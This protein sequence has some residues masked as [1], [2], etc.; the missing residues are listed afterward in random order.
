MIDQAT[1]SVPGA[2][3]IPGLAF[4][5][6]RGEVDY[7][8]MVRILD[9]CNDADRLDYVNTVE[10]IAWVFAH[11]K[12]CDPERDMLFAE[13][14]GE[15]I[16]FSRVWWLEESAGEPENCRVER[17]YVSLGFVHPAWRRRGLGAAM[18]RYDEARLRDTARAHPAGIH[19]LFRAWAEGTQD[20]AHALFASA[21][22]APVRHLIMM[23]RPIGLPL[24][25]APLPPGLEVRP[26]DPNQI[27]AIWDAMWEARRDH[28]GYV[29]P[30]Q[31][32]YERWT[33]GRLFAPELWQVAWEGNQVAGMVLNRLDREQNKQYRRRRGYTQ[34]I[35]VRR[36]WRRR[37]LAR[38]LLAQS[39]RMFRD[40]GMEETA[41]GVDTQNPSGALRLYQSMGY[42]E[43]QR[44]TIY[45]KEWAT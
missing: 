45:Q 15:A 1:I 16:A 32:D 21:G 30:T 29:E 27:R 4:R 19:K 39:I 44:H 9:D 41:L 37:G 20:G 42:R 17:L 8:G 7:P 13:I 28:W 18:L 35:F 22:Y 33:R 2:P 10:E 14:D 12:N 43:C 23:T 38:S 26:V 5:R 40:L 3:A 31:Q 24:P 34:D 11:L 6:F 25:E 36:P